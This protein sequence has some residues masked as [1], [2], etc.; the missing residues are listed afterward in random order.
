MKK[1]NLV[2]YG[3]K[4]VSDTTPLLWVNAPA[5]YKVGRIK[6]AELAFVGYA[7]YAIKILGIT[8]MRLL[9]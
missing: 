7:T 1:K 3:F 2:N 5:E 8:E 9:F 6:K 4:T